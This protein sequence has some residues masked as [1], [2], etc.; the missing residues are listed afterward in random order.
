[1]VRVVEL[2]EDAKDVYGWTTTCP[3]YFA[4]TDTERRRLLVVAAVVG[5]S[6]REGR[7]DEG[8]GQV[9]GARGDNP[10]GFYVLGNIVITI[11]RGISL[12]GSPCACWAWSVVLFRVFERIGRRRRLQPR[13]GEL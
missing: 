8:V 13:H 3:C 11:I 9:D 10:S 2:G 4:C 5:A 12:L 6:G 1:M 7:Y